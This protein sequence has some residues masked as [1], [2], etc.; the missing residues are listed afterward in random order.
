MGNGPSINI[1]P[2][3][4]EP[5]NPNPIQPSSPTIIPDI[6]P[7]DIINLPNKIEE[8]ITKPFNDIPVIGDVKVTLDA[9]RDR[10]IDN[11]IHNIETVTNVVPNLVNDV[12]S[13]KNVIDS[14]VDA[15]LKPAFSTV[16]GAVNTFNT[17][18]DAIEREK[19]H[20][21]RWGHRIIFYDDNLT[22][23][24][25]VSKLDPSVGW[26]R[27]SNLAP[28]GRF[29]HVIPVKTVNGLIRSLLSFTGVS[30]V[31]IWCHGY[32][33]CA[34]I[35]D[36]TIFDSNVIDNLEK[37]DN[38][39]NVFHQDPHSLLW[40]RCCSTFNGNMGR[41]FSHRISKVFGIRVAGHTV[42][43]AEPPHIHLHK[44]LVIVYPDQIPVYPD[45]EG[46]VVYTT[47]FSPKVLMPIYIP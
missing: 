32:S 44:G 37:I 1:G 20:K 42:D 47:D 8:E 2:I 14:V 39:K 13:G 28:V 29:T 41:D 12:V 15:S 38:I 17:A 18:I 19:I 26:K 25:G 11:T 4:V 21:L 33:G 46:E 22:L 6:K 23:L 36:D 27:A 5:F 9:V 10:T 45:R 34:Q 7:P 35:G 16:S 24:E 30:E 31:Q 3:R 40:F 43:I